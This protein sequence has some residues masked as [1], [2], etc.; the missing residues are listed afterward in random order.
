MAMKEYLTKIGVH[1][2]DATELQDKLSSYD[3]KHFHSHDELPL[4][5]AVVTWLSKAESLL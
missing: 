2:I 5:R 3:G 1:C 4:A